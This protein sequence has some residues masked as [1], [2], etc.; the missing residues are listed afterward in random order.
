[1]LII[2]AKMTKKL[3]FLLFSSQR[4]LEIGCFFSFLKISALRGTISDPAHPYSFGWLSSQVNSCPTRDGTQLS[5]DDSVS[6]CH[7]SFR[8]LLGWAV[9]DVAL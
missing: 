6:V 2:S 5:S 3:G 9:N 7:S 4:E 8:F 1:M